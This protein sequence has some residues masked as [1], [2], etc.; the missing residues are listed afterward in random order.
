MRKKIIVGVFVAI[1]ILGIVGLVVGL[2]L[3]MTDICETI[4][5]PSKWY[6]KNEYPFKRTTIVGVERLIDGQTR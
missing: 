4:I 3:R 2:F 6:N 5:K 1:V